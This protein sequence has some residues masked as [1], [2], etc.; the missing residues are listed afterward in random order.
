M[1]RESLYK[2][3]KSIQ[4]SQCYKVVFLKIFIPIENKM[5]IGSK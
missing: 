1:L 4:L 5:R 2:W 3:K